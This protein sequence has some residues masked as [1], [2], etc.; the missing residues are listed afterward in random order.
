MQL[1]SL[2]IWR[3]DRTV[4]DRGAPTSPQIADVLPEPGPSRS[5]HHC[6]DR[7]CIDPALTDLAIPAIVA[8]S[9]VRAIHNTCVQDNRATI[10]S[11]SRSSISK[12][13]E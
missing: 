3:A 8:T 13:A 7:A 9:G 12:L 4:S 2:A 6:S 1:A 5:A 11:I 10:P